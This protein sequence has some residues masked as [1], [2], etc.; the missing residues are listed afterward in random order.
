VRL[1]GG[2]AL[3][4]GARLNPDAAVWHPPLATGP[5]VQHA[6]IVTESPGAPA[7]LP[8]GVPFFGRRLRS[9]VASTPE[10]G[11][12][13]QRQSRGYHNHRC[14]KPQQVVHIG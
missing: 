7:G 4:E 13:R 1:P 9:A 2:L 5:A 6:W 14:I 3:A 11:Y 12:L 10:V 8:E